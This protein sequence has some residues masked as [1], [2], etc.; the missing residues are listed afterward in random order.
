MTL[1]DILTS[2]NLADDQS[3]RK[4]AIDQLLELPRDHSRPLD[5]SSRF[6]GAT[7]REGGGVFLQR[8][9]NLA[10]LTVKATRF[11]KNFDGADS[12][13]PRQRPGASVFGELAP[14]GTTRRRYRIRVAPSGRVRIFG[15]RRRNF[16]SGTMLWITR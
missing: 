13:P 4:L 8:E 2:Q 6:S 15:N 11:S 7:V 14:K 3:R 9:G 16:L 5:R 12:I 10:Q 1:A